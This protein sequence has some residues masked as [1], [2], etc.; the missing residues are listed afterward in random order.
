M[1]IVCVEPLG[2]PASFFEEKRAFFA[3]RGD[4]FTY[5]MERS[6]DP[7][8]LAERMSE[9]DAVVVSN[10]PLR[11][12]LL[13]RCPRLKMLSVAFTGLDHI[14]LDYCNAHGIKVRNAAGYSTTAVSE[15]AVGMMLDMLR[16]MT[17][18]DGLTRHGGCRGTLTG[19]ELRGRTVGV[20][21]TGAIGTATI[22]LLLAFGCRVAAYSRTERAEV[23]ELGVRYMPL[24]ELMGCCDIVSLHVPLTTETHHLIDARRIALMQPTALLVN[25]ARGAVVDTEALAKALQEGAVG[26]AAVDVYDAEPPLAADHPLLQ[27]PRCLC[28]PHVGYA[29]DEA[30]EIRAGIVFEN[31]EEMRG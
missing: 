4:C 15:L 8:V 12:A 16:R 29:T 20:V 2:M 19:G 13:K 26:G 27:A 18:L 31:L 5:Y 14:D 24:D 22:R 28:L 1:N 9:A 17:E 10:I 30:F 21:G 25:T 7:E 23:R 3:A 11:D 6:E